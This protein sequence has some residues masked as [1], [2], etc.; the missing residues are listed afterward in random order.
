MLFVYLLITTSTVII[1]ISY[2]CTKIIIFNYNFCFYEVLTTERLGN[3][4]PMKALT[5]KQY[6]R[7]RVFKELRKER[8]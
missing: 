5:M 4:F 8:K 1:S 2:I 6:R 3:A 7:V